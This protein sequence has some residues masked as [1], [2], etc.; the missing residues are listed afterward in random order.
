MLHKLKATIC[1]L[2]LSCALYAQTGSGWLDPVAF[3]LN[4]NL[5]DNAAWK[6][7]LYDDFNGTTLNPQWLTYNTFRTYDLRDIADGNYILELQ[8]GSINEHIKIT[9][10]KYSGYKIIKI[11]D[12]IHSGWHLYNNSFNK[13]TITV[14]KANYHFYGKPPLPSH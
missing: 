13:I 6:L 9:K 4:T 5:C 1:C 12:A 11:K 8:Q 10:T 7:V 2:L 14:N 3:P